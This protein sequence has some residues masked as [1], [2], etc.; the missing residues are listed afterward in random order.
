MNIN[1]EA[2]ERK[3]AQISQ[4]IEEEGNSEFFIK[5]IDEMGIEN[6]NLRDRNGNLKEILA[7]KGVEVN[8]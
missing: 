8:E 3:Y 1:A 4:R 2:D 7:D 5:M 6:E